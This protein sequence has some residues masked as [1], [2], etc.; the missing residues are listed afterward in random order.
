MDG[1]YQPLP[2]FENSDLF[3]KTLGKRKGR[4]VDFKSYKD[5]RKPWFNKL[6]GG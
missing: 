5:L 2:K 3:K 6:E 1:Q 4:R